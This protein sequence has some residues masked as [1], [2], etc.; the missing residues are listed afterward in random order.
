[1]N[2]FAEFLSVYDV[3]AYDV[4]DNINTILN[5]IFDWFKYKLEQ[6]IAQQ[7][8]PVY[9]KIQQGNWSIAIK[10]ECKTLQEAIKFTAALDR[11]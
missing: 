2:D 1:M 7:P 3:S 9:H 10:I 11:L 6:Q 5:S 8:I 4:Y